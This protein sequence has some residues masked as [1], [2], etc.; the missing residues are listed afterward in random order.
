MLHD[1]F[2]LGG[3]RVF[4]QQQECYAAR[5]TL[6]GADAVLPMRPHK[7]DDSGCQNDSDDEIELV[8]ILSQL[9]P[10]FSELHAEPSQREAPGPGTKKSIDM[11]SSAR[12][13]GNTGR[14][15]DKR[16]HHRKYSRYQNRKI[17]PAR[18]K[19]IGPIQLSPAHQNPATIFFH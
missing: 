17:S 14:Q 9:A 16:T 15:R 6:G 7:P 12:H 8:K 11:K 1:E 2:P 5:L 3:L 4:S 10:V 13:A 18:E 19:A